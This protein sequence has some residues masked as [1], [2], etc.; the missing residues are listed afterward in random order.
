MRRAIADLLLLVL[1][2]GSAG[3]IVLYFIAPSDAPLPNFILVGG[4][5]NMGIAAQAL[6]EDVTQK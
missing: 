3:A 5:M 6:W 2:V 4:C 1:F